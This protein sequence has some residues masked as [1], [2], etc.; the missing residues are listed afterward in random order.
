M[1]DNNE[2]AKWAAKNISF[3]H[4]YKS[5]DLFI[6]KSTFHEKSNLN[7]NFLG[8]TEIFMVKPP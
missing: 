6:R 5:I 8:E 2:E 1:L 3:E 4:V 7:N